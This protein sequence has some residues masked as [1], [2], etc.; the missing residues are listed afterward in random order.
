MRD[1]VG[2]LGRLLGSKLIEDAGVLSLKRAQVSGTRSCYNLN[3]IPE[4]YARPTID[5]D[6]WHNIAAAISAALS[7]EDM[8][9]LL[10][11]SPSPR[12]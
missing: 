12:D 6:A 11:T 3:H 5:V 1:P 7:D 9:C 10:Y 8:V 4:L 2:V